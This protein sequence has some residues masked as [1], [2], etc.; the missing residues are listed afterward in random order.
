MEDLLTDNAVDNCLEIVQESFPEVSG[1]PGLPKKSLK[2]QEMYVTKLNFLRQ[3]LRLVLQLPYQFV[4]HAEGPACSTTERC[5][6]LIRG[7]QDDH[8]DANGWSDIGYRFQIQD[9]R[10]IPSQK[11]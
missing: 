2:Y 4:H 11:C 9:S 7:I 3:I 10:V 1:E 6:E 5:M 8:M